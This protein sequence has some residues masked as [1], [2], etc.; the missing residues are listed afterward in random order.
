MKTLLLRTSNAGLYLL[1]CAMAATGLLLELRLDN[2]NKS[3][4][5]LGMNRDD[6]SEFHFLVALVFAAAAIIHI[7]F[8]W[9]WIKMVMS[10]QRFTAA[11][12][13]A[14]IVLS[15]GLLLMPAYGTGEYSH[16]EKGHPSKVDD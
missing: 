6:W 8:N 10:R 3:A 16:K 11:V 14:G 7:V 12:L 4:R 5:I 2:E 15:V 9:P 13:I 1:T